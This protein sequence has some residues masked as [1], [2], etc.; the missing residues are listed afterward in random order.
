MRR[1]P[2]R[3]QFFIAQIIGLG[4]RIRVVQIFLALFVTGLISGCSYRF[5]Y[6]DRKLPEGYA[7]IAIPVFQNKTQVTGIEPYF[8]NALIREFQ[9]SGVAQVESKDQALTFIEGEIFSVEVKPTAQVEGGKT[10]NEETKYLPKNTVLDTAY[11]VIATIRLYLKR[12][13]DKK[14]IWSGTFKDE[15]VYNAAIISV[16]GVN[17][18]NPLYNNSALHQNIDNLAKKM[19]KDAHDRMTERF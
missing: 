1:F 17:S 15:T 9:L 7:S 3:I 18:L 16:P 12:S 8:T 10:G 5:G 14:I 11:R 6:Q 2:I 4:L 13:S 19:M